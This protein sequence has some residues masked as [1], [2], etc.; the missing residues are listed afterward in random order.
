M[1]SVMF[2]WHMQAAS[3]HHHLPC[4]TRSCPP[5]GPKGF[6]R[7]AFDGAKA[8]R[9][10]TCIYFCCPDERNWILRQPSELIALELKKPGTLLVEA[11]Y[12][13]PPVCW[14]V[15][16]TTVL[17]VSKNVTISVLLVHT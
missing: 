5:F 12:L 10:N 2:R 1:P 16:H 13:S 8:G 14:S 11:L 4:R 9:S 17:T 7:T 15:K 3:D 6:P